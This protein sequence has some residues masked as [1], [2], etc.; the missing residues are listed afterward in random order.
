MKGLDLLKLF[1]RLFWYN[2]W[3]LMN[4][5]QRKIREYRQKNRN[6]S[7]FRS[8]VIICWQANIQRSFITNQK[9]SDRFNIISLLFGL[10]LRT[11]TS[12]QRDFNLFFSFLV[13]AV[14]WTLSDNLSDL[15]LLSSMLNT[16]IGTWVVVLPVQLNE[17][18]NFHLLTIDV[19]WSFISLLCLLE[20]RKPT[21]KD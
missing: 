14:N 21:K 11:T 2:I 4:R 17:K 16:L 15:K 1:S 20:I 18:M 6:F 7:L 10:C 12:V 13:A 19:I 3:C 5:N 8:F 9:V